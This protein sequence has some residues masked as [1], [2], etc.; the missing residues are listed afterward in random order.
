MSDALLDAATIAQL[1]GIRLQ[2]FAQPGLTVGGA[3]WQVETASGDGMLGATTTALG[4]AYTGY[5]EQAAKTRGAEAQA[6]AYFD[7]GW[8][9][10][11]TDASPPTLK[12]GDIIQGGGYRFR[13]VG[14]QSDA[15]YPAYLC[16][17]A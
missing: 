13:I 5:V 7:A 3:I 12:P 6:G 16:D 9:H 14:P 11:I 4:A 2:G 15:L 1:Q 8:I 17:L 10:T